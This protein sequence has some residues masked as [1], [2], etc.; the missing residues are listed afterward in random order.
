MD[1]T[2]KQIS[3]A[4]IAHQANKAYCEIMLDFSQ[5]DWEIAPSWQQESVIRGVQFIEENPDAG[6][7]ASHESWMA[8]KVADGW[9]YGPE[10][11]PETKEHPCMV[12]FGDLPAEQ[13]KKDT[14][15]RSIVLALL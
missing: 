3:I 14:L 10:K 11:N 9:K 1:C 5:P 13:Q 7:A 4:R 8:Q 12:P 15:F 2:A 6:D